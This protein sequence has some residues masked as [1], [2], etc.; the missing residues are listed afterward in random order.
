MLLLSYPG[1][2]TNEVNAVAYTDDGVECGIVI[3]R[4]DENGERQVLVSGESIG[5]AM[6][7]KGLNVTQVIEVV[8]DGKKYYPAADAGL[9]AGDILLEFNGIEIENS[10]HLSKLVN[11]NKSKPITVKYKRKDSEHTGT[12][13]PKLDTQSGEYKIGLLVRDSTSGLGTMTFIDLE[14]GTYGALGHAITDASN[15]NIMPVR[16]GYISKATIK[17]IV[18]G[19][20]GAPGELQGDF[21]VH[22]TI[23]TIFDNNSY[24]IFGKITDEEVL[25]S[26]TLMTVASRDS[27]REGD[28]VIICTLNDEGAKYYDIKITKVNEQGK[29]DIKGLVIEAT[30]PKL[31]ALTGG[32]VQGMSGSPIIQ[33]GKLVG[34]VTHVMVNDPQKGYGVYA[35]WMLEEADRAA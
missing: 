20:Q 25:K 26:G 8:T 3:K 10:N 7:T 28:A 16:E 27:V 13:K 1:N 31:L 29:K 22:K 12:L 32:I 18:M 21:S 15:G 19:K 33:D 34:A 14:K 23:G 9:R 4:P 5:I 11:E 35:D 24:G 17:R 6:M 2:Q 30:D